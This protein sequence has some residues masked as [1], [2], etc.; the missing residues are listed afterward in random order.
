MTNRERR[1]REIAYHLW[2][3][4]GRPEGESHSH[5][6]WLAAEAQFEAENTERED[7]RK[8]AGNAPAAEAFVEP[9]AEP[10]VKAA[11]PAVKAGEPVVK[12]GEPAVK[13]AEPAV[14]A[15][16]P[17]VERPARPTRRKTVEPA[18][19]PARSTWSKAAEPPPE[20]KTGSGQGEDGGVR[21]RQA[22]RPRQAE[23]GREIAE[24]RHGAAGRRAVKDA[25]DV[26]DRKRRIPSVPGLIRNGSVVSIAV[27]LPSRDPNSPA[28]T[29]FDYLARK[30]NAR[31]RRKDWRFLRKRACMW[32]SAGSRMTGGQPFA[33]SIASIRGSS[34]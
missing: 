27:R 9:P 17:A 10:A 33:P 23:A 8:D 31:A 2:E 5:R 21:G 4:E 12:A 30:L 1:I 32:A 13:A 16:E 24:G 20:K 28:G 29:Q 22:G 11:E 6:L 25:R 34:W 14:K 3:Q 15:A 7:E 18:E 26:D 19:K